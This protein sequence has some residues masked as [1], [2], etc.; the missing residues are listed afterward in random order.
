M[1]IGPLKKLLMPILRKQLVMSC[2]KKNPST[3]YPCPI[4]M[5][6]GELGVT[7]N[8]APY[9][10]TMTTL[11]ISFLIFIYLTYDKCT[12]HFGSYSPFSRTRCGVFEHI[13]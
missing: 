13:D 1:I 3:I 8:V 4:P 6:L 11:M 7:V 5:T 2:P 9:H 10:K 12:I